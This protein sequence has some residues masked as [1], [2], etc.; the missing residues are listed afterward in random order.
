MIRH[1]IQ[2]IAPG[3]H[4]FH[5]ALGTPDPRRCSADYIARA[6]E[7]E[8]IPSTKYAFYYISSRADSLLDRSEYYRWSVFSPTS[9]PTPFSIGRIPLPVIYKPLSRQKRRTT[10]ILLRR[11]QCFDI[12]PHDDLPNVRTLINIILGVVLCQM[13]VS[14]E[15]ILPHL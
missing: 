13:G 6:I 8:K 12:L 15:I 2:H 14:S 7:R 3:H 9:P 4:S 5:F 11:A 1:T 10:G